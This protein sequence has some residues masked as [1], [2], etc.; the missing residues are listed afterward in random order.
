MRTTPI[1]MGGIEKHVSTVFLCSYR[2][3]FEICKCIAYH[4][5]L[6]MFLHIADT[7]ISILKLP[8]KLSFANCKPE[9][10]DA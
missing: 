4:Y 9:V 3:R 2:H 8:K 10:V 6:R 5:R 1:D 7:S